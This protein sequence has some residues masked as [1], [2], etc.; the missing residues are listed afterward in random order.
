VGVAMPKVFKFRKYAITQDDYVTSSRMATRKRI[1]Q[2][3][4]EIIPDTEAKIDDAFLKDGWTE[5]NF[6][7][8]Q[9]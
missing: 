8:K 9:T 7:L 2:L 3:G 4:G 1:K 5:K 6:D